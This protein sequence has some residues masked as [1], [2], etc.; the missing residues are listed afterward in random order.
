MDEIEP[1]KAGELINKFKKITIKEF[2]DNTFLD[3]IDKSEHENSWSKIL[4]F[5]FSPNKEHKLYE[6]LLKSFFDSLPVENVNGFF[7]KDISDIISSLKSYKFHNL[8]NYKVKTEQVTE[9]DKRIDILITSDDFVIG[10]ENK[11]NAPLYNDLDDYFAKVDSNCGNIKKPLLVVLS[12]Y[13]QTYKLPFDSNNPLDEK[14]LRKEE[15]N[16][17]NITYEKLLKNIKK[18]LGNYYNFSNTKY[19]IFFLDFLSNIEKQLNLNNMIEN[20][21]LVNFLI[22]NNDGIKRL[23]RVHETINKEL[24]NRLLKLQNTISDRNSSLLEKSWLRKIVPED[25]SYKISTGNEGGISIQLKQKL[26]IWLPMYVDDDY[27][28]TFEC[29]P[30][31]S[32]CDPLFCQGFISHISK[33][34]IA[35]T[36]TNSSLEQLEEIISEYFIQCVEFLNSW[37]NNKILK[38]D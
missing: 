3:I 22:N 30:E 33:Q 10:I 18:N 4:A 36:K 28:I 26:I 14:R 25:F 32:N 7:D 34:N 20:Y 11:V 37:G 13:K 24:H 38:R 29:N 31:D 23:I 21:E 2:S 19:F 6:L 27:K 17:P 5:Y 15:R 1:N 8:Y 35:G 12:K 9:K 16:Y